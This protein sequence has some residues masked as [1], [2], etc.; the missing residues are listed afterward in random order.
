M[1]TLSQCTSGV[2]KIRQVNAVACLCPSEIKPGRLECAQVLVY[3]W[4]SS[5]MIFNGL[6]INNSAWVQFYLLSWRKINFN[7]SMNIGVMNSPISIAEPSIKYVSVCG[8]VERLTSF[9]ITN[10]ASMRKSHRLPAGIVISCPYTIICV[11]K[12]KTHRVL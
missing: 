6:W 10:S 4:K 1:H 11:W 12:L 8:M 5:E 7:R 3:C 9:I 2:V